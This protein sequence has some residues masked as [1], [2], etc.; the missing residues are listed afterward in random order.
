MCPKLVRMVLGLHRLNEAF[1]PQ[2]HGI[3]Q[4]PFFAPL[5]GTLPRPEACCVDARVPW[6]V[7]PTRRVPSRAHWEPTERRPLGCA[8]STRPTPRPEVPGAT[9]CRNQEPYDPP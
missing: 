8:S 4:T 5:R 2:E 9:I 7:T 3:V 6:R 1:L